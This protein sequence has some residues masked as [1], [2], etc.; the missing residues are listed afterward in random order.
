MTLPKAGFFRRIYSAI[1]PS[2]V[3]VEVA[4]EIDDDGVVRLTPEFALRNQPLDLGSFPIGADTRENLNGH[5]VLIS[6]EVR[7]VLALTNGQ[8]QRLAASKAAEIIETL[9]ER[10]IP[11]K[12]SRGDIN[13]LLQNGCWQT[14]L[15]LGPERSLTVNAELTLPNGTV[16]EAPERIAEGMA[17]DGYFA[18][19]GVIVR[20]AKTGTVADRVLPRATAGPHILTGDDVPEFVGAVRNMDPGSAAI[21]QDEELASLGIARADQQGRCIDITGNDQAISV[22]PQ[23]TSNYGN[24]QV[25]VDPKDVRAAISNDEKWVST[26]TGWTEANPEL[27]TEVEAETERLEA[28]YGDLSALS[29]AKIPEFLEAAHEINASSSSPWNAYV[30]EEVKGAHKLVDIPSSVQFEIGVY[31]DADQS[32]LTLSPIY[33]HQRF[34]LSHEQVHERLSNGEKWERSGSSWVKLDP[35]K[36]DRIEGAVA[37]QKMVRR[38]GGF[39]FSAARREEVIQ[40]FSLIGSVQHG[41]A[42]AEFLLKLADFQRIEE[43]PPPRGLRAACELRSYQQ[44]G[45]NWYVF[46]R[47]YGLN[48]ILA[49]DMGLGKTLQT[50]AAIARAKEVSDKRMPSL[51]ICPT[52]L[53][54][55]WKEEVEKF[56]DNL[57]PLAYVGSKSARELLLFRQIQR[58]DIVITTYGLAVN[59]HAAL[60]K[61]PWRYL[62]VDE[63]HNIKNP[64]TNRTKAIKT[65]PA[66]HKLALTGTPIQNHVG[67]LW[68][69][70]DLVMPNYLGK[71]ASFEKKY[72]KPLRGNIAAPDNQRLAT[73]LKERINPFILRRLKKEVATEL[74]DKIEVPIHVELKPAQVTLYKA[75]RDD[76]EFKKM[77][78]SV[79]QKGASRSGLQILAMYAKARNICNHPLIEHD[80]ENILTAKVGDSGKL[81]ALE[82]LLE[83][84]VEGDHRCLIFC[85]STMMLDI[86]SVHLSK[87][88]CE[89]LR[90]DGGTKNRQELVNQFNGDHSITAFL[91]STKAGGTGLNL[92]GADTVIFYDHDWNPANDR[93]AEDRAYRIGQTMNVTVY[94]LISKGTIEDRIIERQRLKEG[95]ADSI[96]GVDEQGFKDITR[97]Q[98]LGLFEYSP[99]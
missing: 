59:D 57:R 68:S 10:K 85:Q 40:L 91:I 43:T 83:E 71:R 42:Y 60:S 80:R 56:F 30:S 65:I 53:V 78:K 15:E 2:P 4:I 51:V 45:Y 82:E 18:T 34:Q 95:V 81:E 39:A 73:H 89:H 1:N 62:V 29:G 37:K 8:Q 47:R 6:P 76:A 25:A 52:S 17:G 24:V 58:T 26:T 31:D 93:Q 22:A 64:S 86:L 69:L 99:E 98:L 75:L 79:E 50:L 63:A 44:H 88:N 7:R 54:T 92:T 77:I 19:N 33:N 35:E 20:A 61:I 90:I 66:Q 41:E 9:R 23:I 13:S 46:L 94:H 74:P 97:E 48:G 3:S 11:L 21:L 55:N 12:T 28:Q 72:V 70:F 32:M 84:V 36:H 38:N 27:L 96:I 14:K 67:E 5:R 49:D 87:W 16:I